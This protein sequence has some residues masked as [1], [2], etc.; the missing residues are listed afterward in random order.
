MHAGIDAHACANGEALAAMPEDKL[1]SWKE[2]A[3]YLKCD[4]STARRWEKKNG[5]PVY[6]VVDGGG[7]VFAYPHEIDA[8]IRKRHL[9]EPG[10]NAQQQHAAPSET[11]SDARQ[12]ISLETDPASTMFVPAAQSQMPSPATENV[13]KRFPVSWPRYSLLG[14]IVIVL[15]V[16]LWFALKNGL[17][18]QNVSVQTTGAHNSL[19]LASSFSSTDHKGGSEVNSSPDELTAS[20]LKAAVKESQLWET[21]TLYSAPW[22]CDANDLKRYWLP[23]SKAYI[24]VGESVSR[25]NER[26]S[27]YGFG[28]RLLDFE[29]RYVRISRDGLSAEVGTREHW[30]LP[31]YTH[32]EVFVTSRNPDQ[33]PYEIDYLLVKVNG[34]WY[35]KSTST[36]YSQWKPQQITCKNWPQQISAQLQR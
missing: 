28:A 13:P 20:E 21:L 35:L 34:R 8:W 5:L 14:G 29:F 23:G 24:D 9:E 3:A 2:I 4:E 30:W 16:A 25:L 27:H 6:R 11:S 12:Y 19:P 33:G 31:V 1:N 22:N 18:T 17:P 26:G 10:A 7:S 15:A 36:P 32:E